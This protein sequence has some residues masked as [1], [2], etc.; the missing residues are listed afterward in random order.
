MALKRNKYANMSQQNM[1]T[2][3]I[4]T[5]IMLAQDVAL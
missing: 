2:P 1:P 5:E 4:A 3:A